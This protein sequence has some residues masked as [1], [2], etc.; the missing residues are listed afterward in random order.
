MTELIALL[1]SGKGTWTEVARLM[2]SKPWDK[3]FL[4]TNDFGKDKFVVDDKCEVIVVDFDQHV[5]ELRN[6]IS[7]Q[8]SGKIQGLEV[9]L[10]VGSGTGKEHMALLSALIGLGVG[11]RFVTVTKKGFEEL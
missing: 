7:Q 5:F 10:H 11:F 3:I 1:S 4:I 6:D 8:L 9:A 2:K